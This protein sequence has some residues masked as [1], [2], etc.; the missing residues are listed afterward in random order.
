M[1]LSLDTKVGR[2]FS[3][4][5]LIVLLGALAAM[6]SLGRGA[7]PSLVGDEATYLMQAESLAF[8]F[9]LTYS[10]NDFD[11]FVAHRGLRPEGLILQ[12]GD[13]EKA[14]FGKPF[15][16]ALYLAP[17]VRLAP[18]RGPFVANAVLLALA[19]LAAA[20]T[21]RRRLGASAPL[22]IAVAVFAS[23][24]FVYT[25][26]AHA[27]LFLMCLTALALALVDAG[28]EGT[29]KRYL[30]IVRWSVAGIL[31]AIVAFSRPMYAVLFLPL[32]A[33]LYNKTRGHAGAARP[34]R[35][36]AMAMAAG[37]LT[38]VLSAGAMHQSLTGSWTSY[39][40]VRGGFYSYTGFPEVDLAAGSDWRESLGGNRA[41]LKPSEVVEKKVRVSLWGWNSLY[42]LAGRHVGFLPYFLPLFLA[43]FLGRPIAARP[44]GAWSWSLVLAAGLCLAAF[45]HLRPFNFW[46][47][48]GAV[49]NRYFLPLYPLFWFL[50]RR[51]L[52][53][54]WLVGSV[55]VAGL[56]LAPLW[57]S[58]RAFPLFDGTTYRYVSPV[59]QCC[60][61]YETSQ[62]H[63]KPSGQEDVRHNDLWIKFLDRGVKAVREG[64]RLRLRDGGGTILVGSAEPMTSLDVELRAG[65]EV[66]L[67]VE[68]GELRRL[69]RRGPWQL[70]RVDLGRRRAGHPMWWTSWEPFYLYRLRFRIEGAD[71]APFVL[72]GVE[73][74]ALP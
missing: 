1:T 74:G 49:G 51:P 3:W 48:G 16:Y 2:I 31:V 33:A 62:S 13:S 59:A 28:R 40:A 42:L 44:Q 8:D 9:D 55:V 46:G 68:G 71:T 30:E 23:V 4:A 39:G 53:V 50:P 20:W 11:R 27:D 37:A 19:A 14:T 54:P 65:D 32:V 12:S 24:T 45:L 6:A 36:E 72:R 7:W 47:G 67:Q 69:G 29:G 15:F 38:L 61:P 70:L 5:V 26:W 57:L 41:W 60:L 52:R 10:R 43:V 18:V 56:F 34:W 66:T 35:L 25:F 64:E 22:W 58:P 63:L 21:L 73:T 17:Y